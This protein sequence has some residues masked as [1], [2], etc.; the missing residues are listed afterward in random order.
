MWLRRPASWLGLLLIL[1]GGLDFLATAAILLGVVRDPLFKWGFA[2]PYLVVDCSVIVAGVA[3][4]GGYHR[5]G[6][7]IGLLILFDIVF[8][9]SWLALLSLWN[10]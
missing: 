2:V 4:I 9:Y 8:F 7:A 1:L 3:I 5:L 6:R 10:E